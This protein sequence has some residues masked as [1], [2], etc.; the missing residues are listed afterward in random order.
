MRWNGD[1]KS[2]KRKVQEETELL[3]QL[4]EETKFEKG[5]YLALIIAS[6]TTLVPVALFILLMYYFVSM[7]F[8][9]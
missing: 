4:R 5:D 6:F 9:G 8:F 2:K 7:L 3:N 1:I